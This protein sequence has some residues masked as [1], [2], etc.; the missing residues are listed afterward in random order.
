ME[1]ECKILLDSFHQHINYRKRRF[2][3]IEHLQKLLLSLILIEKF[4]EMISN[5]SIEY[6]THIELDYLEKIKLIDIGVFAILLT[7][8]SCN[9]LIHQHKYE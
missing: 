1:I 8:P 7:L 5:L 3:S 9:P 4:L 2:K 6:F